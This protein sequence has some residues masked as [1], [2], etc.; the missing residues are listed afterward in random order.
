MK[1]QVIVCGRMDKMRNLI[2]S[3]CVLGHKTISTE[4]SVKEEKY[5]FDFTM[6]YHI[7]DVLLENNF[8]RPFRSPIHAIDE[9]FR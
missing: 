4:E 5:W 8:I 9:K 6:C 2:H 3:H 7:F 1:I